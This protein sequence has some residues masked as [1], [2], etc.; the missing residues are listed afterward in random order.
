MIFV[1]HEAPRCCRSQRLCGHRLADHA[2]AGGR[3]AGW[4]HGI[5]ILVMSAYLLQIWGLIHDPFI[6]P[7]WSKIDGKF[8]MGSP[9][10]KAL[11]SSLKKDQ[12]EMRLASAWCLNTWAALMGNQVSYWLR[13][14]L[15]SCLGFLSDLL[16]CIPGAGAATVHKVRLV[17]ETNIRSL[18]DKNPLKSVKI[19][20]PAGI[21]WLLM[22]FA[23]LRRVC[24]QA[25]CLSGL[26][27]SL[28]QPQ[29]FQRA[30]EGMGEPI[31]KP[32]ETE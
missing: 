28:A 26:V 12:E 22:V 30:A 15:F 32:A 11:V 31:G 13:W 18:W 4:H 9:L 20:Q 27:V 7:Q 10:W 17:E 5:W 3:Q 6:N 24:V 16:L 1:R 14:C 29:H 23:C 21:W 8:A 19:P 2:L 25:V